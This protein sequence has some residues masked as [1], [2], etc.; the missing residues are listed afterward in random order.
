MTF[1]AS[2]FEHSIDLTEVLLDNSIRLIKSICLSWRLHPPGVA[3]PIQGVET[4]IALMIMRA[5]NDGS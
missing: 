4:A 3:H 1:P 5:T 2:Y